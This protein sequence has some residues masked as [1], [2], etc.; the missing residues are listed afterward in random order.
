MFLSVKTFDVFD[1]FVM[2]N[3]F[4]IINVSMMKNAG[5]CKEL[6]HNW[7]TFIDSKLKIENS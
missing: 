7:F 5:T 4:M 1:I 6:L 2:F 3:H